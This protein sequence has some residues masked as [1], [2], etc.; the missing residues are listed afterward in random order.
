MKTS[1][2]VYKMTIAALLC[3]IGIIIPMYSPIKILLEPASFTLASHVATMIAMFIS[4]ATAVFVAIG[5]TLGFFIGGFP[6]VVVLRAGTHLV[7]ALIGSS[8][9]KNRR[10]IMDGTA[11]RA[12]LSL[13]IAIIHAISEML[14]VMPFYFGNGMSQAYYA[15]GFIVSIVLLVG[16][17]TL[18]HSLVDFAIASFIWKPLA[19]TTRVSQL[20]G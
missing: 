7:W 6:I 8:I 1:E 4:P 16:V 14:V 11:S 20:Q 13:L 3:A 2:K 18:V 17:G 5:T 15:K 12:G 19:K 9:L 10:N